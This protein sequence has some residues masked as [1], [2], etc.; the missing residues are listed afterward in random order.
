MDPMSIALLIMAGSKLLGGIGGFL[1]G[2]AKAKALQ[3]AAT[4]ARQ[5]GSIKANI[6]LREGDKVAATAAVGAAGGGGGGVVGSSMDVLNQIAQGSMH[7]ARTA[8][9]EGETEAR[10]R[11]YE[12]SVAKTEGTMKLIS[13]VA[14]AGTSFLSGSADMAA[15]RQ[16]Q[17]LQVSRAPTAAPSDPMRSAGIYK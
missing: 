17:G 9:Y 2:R 15:Q 6:A 4:Q 14:E 5:E 13:S 10:A 1:G 16:T 7:N 11:R 12:A 8:I 3:Q